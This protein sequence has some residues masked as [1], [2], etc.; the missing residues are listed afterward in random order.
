M[1]SLDLGFLNPST[2][3]KTQGEEQSREK[4]EK[5]GRTNQWVQAEK[6]KRKW[7]V[8]TGKVGDGR[9]KKRN[10]SQNR[11]ITAQI[12]PSETGQH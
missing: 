4:K 8:R 11:D 10:G 1:Y 6:S 3:Q 12:I 9:K 2:N 5:Q 7:E